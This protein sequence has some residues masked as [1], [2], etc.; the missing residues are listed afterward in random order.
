MPVTKED[1]DLWDL[2]KR[3]NILKLLTG[4]AIIGIF[5][6][7]VVA[8]TYIEIPAK[9]ELIFTHLI[10]IIEGA[11]VG[12]LCAYYFGSSKKEHDLTNDNRDPVKP[13]DKP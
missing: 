3:T 9:N 4:L 10:G 6:F 8:L 5:C 1:M 12:N 13:P 2:L 7:V 11:F